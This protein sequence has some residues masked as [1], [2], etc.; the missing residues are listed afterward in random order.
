[1]ITLRFHYPEDMIP[2]Q[3]L[4]RSFFAS[5]GKVPLPST[6][7]LSGN[8]ISVTANSHRSGTFFFPWPHKRLGMVFLATDTLCERN[9]P[10]LL[11][12]E[13][14]RG[15]LGRII[16]RF[17]EMVYFGFKPSASL[18]ATIRYEVS[19]LARL[20]TQDES[21]PETELMAI[22]QLERLIIL[23]GFLV[24]SFIDQSLRFRHKVAKR[25]P[26]RFGIHANHFF[27]HNHSVEI[28]RNYSDHLVEAFHLMNLTPTW[29]ELEPEPDHYRWDIFESRIKIAQEVGFVSIAGP[30]IE[31]NESSLPQW[32]INRLHEPGVF[33]Q[34]AYR[35]LD[36]FLEHFQEKV[37][38]WILAS[39]INTPNIPFF[40]TEKIFEI[41]QRISVIFENQ[42]LYQPGLVCVDQPWGDYLL[43]QK[44]PYN[45]MQIAEKLS[46]L[47]GID[48]ILLDLNI[49]LISRASYPRD[50]MIMS[51]MI[52]QWSSYGKPLYI[53]LGIP[54]E[55]G[56]N[57]DV[58]DEFIGYSF[59]WSKKTQQEWIH[60]Y[61][62]V[63]LCKRSVEGVFWN[64]IEDND[65]SE[66]HSIGLF[67]SMGR[68]KPA[69]KKL[70]SL[71]KTYID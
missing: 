38:I 64:L 35:Y 61:L 4:K 39:R 22:Q 19:E 7:S 66:F 67:D 42:N 25:L 14:A 54:S 52:D 10:Y 50:P 32:L 65:V 51:S 1:M 41:V 56:A 40:S 13:L 30:I 15:Q 70:A 53:S 31:F 18:R 49:G 59:N 68:L 5:W 27:R 69:F 36:T 71:R 43:N 37:D 12:K 33:E 57:P 28:F 9:R 45:P 46:G 48:G 24:D 17:V 23:C 26:I 47:S 6:I 8:V 62:P 20:V 2:V 16:R 44:C 11:A 58:A 21:L 29:R 60:R 34:C 3:L 63:I 55:L